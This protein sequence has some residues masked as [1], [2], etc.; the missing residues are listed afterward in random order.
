[1]QYL[2]DKVEW[3]EEDKHV[4]VPMQIEMSKKL[5]KKFINHSKVRAKVG[6]VLMPTLDAAGQLAYANVQAEE[7]IKAQVEARIGAA[8]VVRETY[9]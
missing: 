5:F 9:P 8:I 2:E 1:M 7:V 3:I 6:L 4:S